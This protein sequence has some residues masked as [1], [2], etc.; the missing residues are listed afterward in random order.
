MVEKK[1][2]FVC[3]FFDAS[4]VLGIYLVS[5]LEEVAPVGAWV[6][7]RTENQ[8][9]GLTCT[10]KHFD[11]ISNGCEVQGKIYML[12]DCEVVEL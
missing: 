5:Y 1:V 6:K 3:L 8:A 11:G 10:S 2:V 9:L 12:R 4:A 7:S